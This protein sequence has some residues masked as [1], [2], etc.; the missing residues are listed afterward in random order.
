[1]KKKILISLIAICTMLFAFGMINASAESSGTCGNNL[2]WTLD[3]AGTLTI[4]GQ[5]TM[6]N[7]GYFS[8]AP[9]YSL[10]E[11]ITKVVIEDG[12][13][14]IGSYAFYDCN[15]LVSVTISHNVT[16]I[17]EAAF[18]GCGGLLSIIIPDSVTDIGMGVFAR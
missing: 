9:W 10:I 6:T 17:G 4:S 8:F 14:S 1:M 13:T 12:V 15:S 18:A 7:W 2:T 11:K 5:G 16:S 3:D